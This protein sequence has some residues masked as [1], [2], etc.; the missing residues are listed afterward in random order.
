MQTLHGELDP[1]TDAPS[2]EI[3]PSADID[4]TQRGLMADRAPAH[5][6]EV[7]ALRQRVAELESE[8]AAIKAATQAV[9]A[10]D[11]SPHC[12]VETGDTEPSASRAPGTSVPAPDPGFA[13][14]WSADTRPASFEERVAERA[15]F[16]STTVDEES[17]TWLL[18][19]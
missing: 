15:F 19:Q 11:P 5:A 10:A 18:A 2:A 13:Q 3:D 7:R 16:R 9:V 4:P 14:A 1:T 8:L 6:H 17:R 12:A